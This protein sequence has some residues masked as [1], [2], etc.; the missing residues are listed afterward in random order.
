MSNNRS[1]DDRFNVRYDVRHTWLP[2]LGDDAKLKALVGRIMSQRLDRNRPLWELWIVEGLPNGQWAMVTQTHHCMIDGV[3]G[4]DISTVLMLVEPDD[5]IE[6]APPWRPR[7][8]PSGLTLLTDEAKRGLRAPLDLYVGS[9]GSDWI[10]R[11]RLAE[12]QPESVPGGG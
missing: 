5:S 6:E 2:R 12:A 3:S 11:C 7:K 10:A 9:I 4:V 8:A 1:D